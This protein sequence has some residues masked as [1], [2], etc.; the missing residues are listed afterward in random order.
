MNKVLRSKLTIGQATIWMMCMVV[1]T[2]VLTIIE[3]VRPEFPYGLVCTFSAITIMLSFP[4]ANAHIQSCLTK[5]GDTT[6][7]STVAKTTEDE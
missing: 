2:I 3:N 4:V 5:Y 6:D 1:N 7:R